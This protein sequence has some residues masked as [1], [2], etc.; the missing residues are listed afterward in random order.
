MYTRLITKAIK[1]KY[2]RMFGI[3]IMVVVANWL[4][5]LCLLM[6]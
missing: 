2:D 3:V 5:Y 6:K 4:L 1:G